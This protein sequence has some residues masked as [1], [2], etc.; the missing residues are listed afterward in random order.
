MRV[1]ENTMYLYLQQKWHTV[2]HTCYISVSLC[3]FD[4]ILHCNLYW[5][6]GSGTQP[7]PLAQYP[8]TKE[9]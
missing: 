7:V 4:K 5:F 9:E 6:V 8:L 2:H 3:G 1:L